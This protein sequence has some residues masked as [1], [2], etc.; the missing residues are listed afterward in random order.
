MVM[1]GMKRLLDARIVHESVDSIA[2][3]NAFG[4]SG[5]RQYAFT[6]S[7]KATATIQIGH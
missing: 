2:K 5:G 4:G 1:V 3:T 7:A 6:P